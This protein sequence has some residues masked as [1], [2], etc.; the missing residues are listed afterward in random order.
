LSRDYPE[1]P[2]VGVVAVVRCNDRFLLVERGHE[3][4]KGRW[5]FPG[6]VQELGETVVE[7]ALRELAEETGVAAA[8][9]RIL[10][11]LDAIDR[12]ESGAVRRH[13][14]L[15]AVAL[16]WTGGEGIAGDDAAA[17]GWFGADELGGLNVL[18]A[19]ATLMRLALEDRPGTE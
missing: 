6:G 1:R 9:P 3:P 11:V 5:G 13:Y 15:V 16:S 2:Y 18:P 4:N 17:L 19:V 12:D 8:S 7:A 14:T 10:T